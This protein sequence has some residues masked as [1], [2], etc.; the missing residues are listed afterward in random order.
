[1]VLIFHSVK[2]SLPDDFQEVYQTTSRKSARRLTGSLLTDL[3]PYQVESKL[4][5]AEE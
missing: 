2:G 5:F 1:M 4:V 3:L